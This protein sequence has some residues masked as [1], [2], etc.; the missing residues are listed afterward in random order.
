MNASWDGWQEENEQEAEVDW[1]L[2]SRAE[3]EAVICVFRVLVYIFSALQDFTSRGSK[4]YYWKYATSN[5]IKNALL[6]NILES[7]ISKNNRHLMI[8]Y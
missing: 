4:I 7:L 5:S 6:V 1:C 8:I 3:P 2:D